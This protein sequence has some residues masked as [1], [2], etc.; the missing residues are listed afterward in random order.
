VEVVEDG[1]AAARATQSK[2][3]DLILMDCQMP[4]M[5]GYESTRLIRQS[6]KQT[7]RRVPIVGLSA[8][9][10]PENRDQCLSAG[11]D[12]FVAKPF[13]PDKLLSLCDALVLRRSADLVQPNARTSN[14]HLP[15]ALSR[16]LDR[17]GPEVLRDLSLAYL[18]SAPPVFAELVTSIHIKD[19]EAVR[20]LA[21][22][23]RGGLCRLAT[24]S[25]FDALMETDEI[26][27]KV[28][29]DFDAINLE[30]LQL[31]F[32]GAIDRAREWA[33]KPL[34]KQIGA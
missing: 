25:L 18:S 22:W 7:G 28:P 23:L 20:R 3:F 24:P 19:G 16:L 9:A 31:E 10:F 11:M 15:A 14:G 5:D 2:R 26:C 13:D 30:R 17:L 12:G 29:V 8:N 21:H 27:S 6:E 33:Q 34:T 1:D 32:E 4:V